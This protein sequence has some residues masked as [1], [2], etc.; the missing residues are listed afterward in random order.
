MEEMLKQILV[1]LKDMRTDVNGLK[2]MR[3]DV[4]ELIDMRSDI[5]EL[6]DMR[7]DINELKDIRSDINEIKQGQKRLESSLDRMQ[8]NLIESLGDYTEKIVIHFDNKTDALNKRVYSIE[9]DI[10]GLNRQ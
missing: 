8:K 5:N 10:Q 6:K 9:T 4:N 3:S 2:E 7:S 1:E